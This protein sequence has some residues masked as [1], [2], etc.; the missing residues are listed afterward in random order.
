[1][2]MHTLETILDDR[3]T[4]LT[5]HVQKAEAAVVRR[6]SELGER[7]ADNA[8]AVDTRLGQVMN[9]RSKELEARLGR[10]MNERSRE[11]DARLG[12]AM[13]ERSEELDAFAERMMQS[14][15]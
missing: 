14:L 11:H 9:E 8:Q 13:N 1:M 3:T 4:A 2:P 6:I 15:D 7:A 12:K 10:A 5:Q